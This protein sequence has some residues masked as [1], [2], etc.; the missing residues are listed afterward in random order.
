MQGLKWLEIRDAGQAEAEVW[1]WGR[2]ACSRWA[3]SL[4]T[5]P[6]RVR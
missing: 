1:P 5:M 6:L 2:C 4:Q 3:K